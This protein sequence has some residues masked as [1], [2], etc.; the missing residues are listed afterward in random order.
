MK[1]TIKILFCCAAIVC[2]TTLFSQ[3]DSTNFLRNYKAP[4]YEFKQLNINVSGK[5]YTN[6]DNLSVTNGEVILRYQKYVNTTKIQKLH[7]T[8]FQMLGSYYESKVNSIYKSGFLFYSSNRFKKRIFFNEKWFFGI[9]DYSELFTSFDYQNSAGNEASGTQLNLELKPGFSIG[10]GRVEPIFHGRKVLDIEKLLLKSNII[11]SELSL[12]KRNVL[13]NTLAKIENKRYFDNRLM[14]I[15]QLEVIDSVL[16][17]FGIIS[18][19]DIAYFTHLSDAYLFSHQSNRLSG[20][21]IEFNL[22]HS[23]DL[24]PSSNIQTHGILSYAFYLPQSYSL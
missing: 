10:H 12:E 17:S 3:Q 21:Q 14:Q 18:N 20:K 4:D 23:L 5:N 15:Y 24:L 9:S 13:S 6:V 22:V 7:T 16:Q 11:S 2:S 1:I 8:N 19:T